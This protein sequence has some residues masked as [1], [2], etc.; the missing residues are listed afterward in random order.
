MSNHK[1]KVNREALYHQIIQNLKAG[2]FAQVEQA[3]IQ[4][5]T[6]TKIAPQLWVFLGEALFRQGYIYE[7]ERVFNRALLLDPQAS[8]EETVFA[9]I[10]HHNDSNEGAANAHIAHDRLATSPD[11]ECRA[12]IAELL[13]VP[14]V[15]VSAAIIVKNEER[16]IC[17]CIDSIKHAVD[18]IIV[19][20]TG[21]TD[22]T[23]ELLAK[24]PEVNV[25][26]AVWQDDFAAARNTAMQY[27]TS[28]WVM[29]LDADE[30]LY[31][32]DTDAIK[33]AAGLFD[34]IS[35][36][37]AY[38]VGRTDLPH[39]KDTTVYNLIRFFPMRHQLRFWG[40]VHEQVGGPDGLHET[41]LYGQALRI[42]LYHDGYEPSIVQMKQ[43]LS[44]NILLLK[45]MLKEEPNNPA[46]LAN[47]GREVLA[48]GDHENALHILLEAEKQARNNT[49]F[50]RISDIHMNLVRIYM[51]KQDFVSA[52]LVCRR[53]IQA[54]PDFPDSYYWLAHIQLL[55]AKHKMSS[56]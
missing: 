12:D 32:E 7:A 10:K 46:T 47:L 13:Q 6:Q 30:Y 16:S 50:A 26:H 18:E 44:R 11:I 39:N 42:R 24:Y 40:K 5:L 43:K 8:W 45:A 41:K 37:A 4:W 35:A 54:V 27:V 14:P 56:R 38:V 48:T 31:T 53:A 20:D 25:Y 15:T 19:L 21:S 29:W 17:R 3:C 33:E 49:N 36:P 23:L 1:S 52:E 51:I 22:Q 9:Q 28:Q 34:N 2:H 55:T